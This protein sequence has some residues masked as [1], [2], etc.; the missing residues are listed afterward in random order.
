MRSFCLSHKD[1]VHIGG[2]AVI[3]GVMMR[4][5]NAV[6]TA[7]RKPNNEISIKKENKARWTKAN[8]LLGL[9]FV[10]GIVTL[11]E[12]MTLGIG[13]LTYSATEA[14]EEENISKTEMG[15][16]FTLSIIF[17]IALFIALPAFAFSKLKMLP[18]NTISLNIIEGLI[19][20]TIFV[21]FLFLVNFMPDMKRVFEYHGAEHKTINAYHEMRS[22]EGFVPDA[23]NPD[24]VRKYSKVHPSC[25]TSFILMVLLVSIFT[26]S[27]LGRPAFLM[28]VALKLSLLPVVAG[29]SYEIIRLARHKKAP[30]I[31]KMLVAPGVL[32]Q[33]IT[34]REPDS[35]QIEVAISA[36]KSVL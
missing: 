34:T 28:R 17:S 21:G 10:R 23:L 25:G 6:A 18:I 2:Q 11:A 35:G 31:A 4:G 9:P 20:M 7:V 33:K 26:F 12:T 29:I 27:F 19:R 16:A 13:S 22:M 30:F 24:S 3:E 32:L 15:F 36:L 14:G 5:E 8:F 1:D